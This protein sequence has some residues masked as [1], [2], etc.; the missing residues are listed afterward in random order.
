M[1]RAGPPRGWCAGSLALGLLTACA[2]PPPPTWQRPDVSPATAHQVELDCHQRA[3][4]TFG[5]GNNPTDAQAVHQEREAYF[6]RCMRG[7][8]FELR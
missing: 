2:P 4:E 5:A 1:T 3:I 8:G 6:V 7:S